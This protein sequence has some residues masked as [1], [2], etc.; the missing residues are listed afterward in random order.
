[1]TLGV[2]N[3]IG[4]FLAKHALHAPSPRSTKDGRARARRLLVAGLV[5][6]ACAHPAKAPPKTAP[7]RIELPS[8][9]TLAD[10][11][12][13]PGEKP[14]DRLWPVGRW[15]DVGPYHAFVYVDRDAGLSIRGTL[16]ASAVSPELAA[17][18]A[19]RGGVR[20][21][22][23]VRWRPP[24]T[25]VLSDEE[26]VAAGLPESPDWLSGYGEQPPKGTLFGA[27]RFDP[28]LAHR[29]TTRGFP[30]DLQ[31]VIGDQPPNPN[32]VEVVWVSLRECTASHCT[33]IVLNA[34]KYLKS[35]RQRDPVR[36]PI[37]AP[38]KSFLRA[39]GPGPHGTD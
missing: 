20:M 13:K 39:E 18:S 3:V 30:D 17:L 7:D 4:R 19:G 10:E 21:T 35:W 12:P 8:V 9:L 33:G 26:R 14:L 22:T 27:W 38:P 11:P 23:R 1:M 31:V 6:T 2:M 32:G 5:V 24:E 28:R 25:R 37:D 16:P 29:F 34:P 15:V 36:F